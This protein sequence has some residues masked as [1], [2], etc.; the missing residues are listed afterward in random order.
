MKYT[1]RIL[2]HEGIRLNTIS[3]GAVLFERGAWSRKMKEDPDGVKDYIAGNVPLRR[4]ATPEK[5]D[6]LAA[7]LVSDEAAFVTES[8]FVIDGGQT[9][10]RTA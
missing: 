2:G 10:M 9:R 5:I 6:M 7:Y 4:F 1:S 8:N 3:P